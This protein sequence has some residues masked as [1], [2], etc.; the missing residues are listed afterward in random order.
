MGF[1]LTPNII[2]LAIL[3]GLAYGMVIFL[4]AAGLAIIF[5][6]MDILNFAH[7]SFFMLGAYITIHIVTYITQNF[8]LAVLT[9]TLMGLLIGVISEVLLLRPLYGKPASQML[10]TLGLMLLAVQVVTLLWPAGLVFPLRD[11]IF[12]GTVDI[13]GSRLYVYRL[14]VILMGLMIMLIL[15]LFLTRTTFGA[16]IRA[17]T[18]NRELAMVY[19]ININFIFTTAFALGTALA[20]FGGAIAS[21]WLNATI[22]IGTNFTLLAFVVVVIGGMKSHRGTFISSIMIGI[23]HQLSAYLLSQVTL[24][25]DLLI[26]ITV[27]L[28]KPEG[29]FG[30]GE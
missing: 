29:L 10:L 5:G 15:D 26:M 13:F 11:F 16:K 14:I 1:A 27:L 30:K 3:D 28:V 7:A 25:I 21:P 9:A 17:G 23:I 24:V 20:F 19:G 22:E 6:L 4:I 2:F 8:I 18:E 12:V